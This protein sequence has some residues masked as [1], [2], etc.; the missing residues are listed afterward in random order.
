VKEEDE[1]LLQ[2]FPR[3]LRLNETRRR[4]HENDNIELIDWDRLIARQNWTPLSSMCQIELVAVEGMP[5]K[6]A[7]QA[8][9]LPDGKELSQDVT[10]WDW[11]TNNRW[12][13]HQCRVFLLHFAKES[14]RK[15]VIHPGESRVLKNLTYLKTLYLIT[16][17]ENSIK[18]SGSVQSRSKSCKK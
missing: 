9:V 4:I 12:Q 2:F 14:S 8:V 5:S 16:R 10:E 13:E 7:A 6:P 18:S 17:M 1:L 3:A 11:G 15:V